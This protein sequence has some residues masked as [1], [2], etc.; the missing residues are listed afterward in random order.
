MKKIFAGFL[1]FFISLAFSHSYEFPSK[2]SDQA[3]ISI[4][5]IDYNDISHTLFSKSCLRIYDK[6]NQFDQ[7]IDFAYFDDFN[8]KYFGLKFFLKNKK[9][10]IKTEEFFKYFL[11]LNQQTN[12]SLTESTLQLSPEEVA[13]IY[14]FLFI[15]HKALPD[16]S[17]EFDILTKNSETHISQILHD[18]Y[19]MVGAQNNNEQY[20]FSDVGKFNLKYKRI[21]DSFVLLSEKESLKFGE[22]D[23][24]SLFS[25]KQKELVIILIIISS[26]FF[27]VTFYQ[28]LVCFFKKLYISSIFKSTQIFDFTILFSSGLSGLLIIFMDLFSNQAMLRNNFEF[29]YLF[30]LNVVAAFFLFKSI[31][32][33]KRRM[34][35]WIVVSAL[36]L[37]YIV[38]VWILESKFPLI[39][40]LFVLPLFLRT[41]YFALVTKTSNAM[42]AP[43]GIPA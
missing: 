9:A 13:Y 3:K 30:P 5:S 20:L 12:V 28:T 36:S 34:I 24:S 23:L 19:R 42:Y 29:L 17:Y 8:D 43:P 39:N 15:M 16:Y 40:V 37:I 38:I 6:Q 21:N 26:L 32:T 33:K 31:S 10:R 2:L 1:F 11:E 25:P 14:N 7:I 18:C 41:S 4:F 27:I 22:E 35:Y